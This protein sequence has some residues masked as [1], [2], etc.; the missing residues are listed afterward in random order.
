MH[1]C[2]LGISIVDSKK[3]SS[4]EINSLVRLLLRYCLLPCFFLL[5]FSVLTIC[6]HTAH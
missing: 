4:L 6:M 2:I 1:A 3:T 5:I